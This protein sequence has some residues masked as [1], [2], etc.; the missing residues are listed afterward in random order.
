MRRQAL[1]T[2]IA[3]LLCACAGTPSRSVQT[4]TIYRDTWG[5]PHIYADNEEAGF[6]ALGYAQAQDR[7][8]Q[9]LGSLLWVRGR[10]AEIMG[11][12]MLAGDVETRRWMNFEEG[13]KGFAR[14]SPELQRNYRAFVAGAKKF[15][16]ENPKLVPAWAPELT[17][18]ALTAITRNM[19]LDRLQLGVGPGGVLE[20]GREAAALVFCRRDFSPD[21]VGAKAPPTTN[22]KRRISRCRQRLQRMGR[23][24]LAHRQRRNDPACRSAR[25]GEQ[26]VL[27]RVPHGR[28]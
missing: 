11:D 15:M 10:L 5:V 24:P 21:H 8:P 7:L 26:P 16:S 18:E 3:A 1:I 22:I 6:Y 14:L 19:Y 4:A 17:P 28:G 23:L 9:L 20:G 12:G 2:L 25:R 13:S 27:L